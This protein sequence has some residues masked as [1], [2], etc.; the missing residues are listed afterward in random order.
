MSDIELLQ[1]RVE[2]ER[3]ARKAAE[4]LLEQKSLEVYQKN[5]EFKRLADHNHA[6]VETAAEGIISYGETGVIETFNR[7][8]Q[9]IFRVCKDQVSSI[10]ALFDLSGEERLILFPRRESFLEQDED[11]A[12]DV[13]AE[14]RDP[15][16]LWGRRPDGELFSVEVAVSKIRTDGN[17]LYTALVRDLTRRRILESRLGQAQK[18][19][20]VGQL[21]A[22]ISHEINTP[23]QFVGDNIQ[24]LEAAFQDVGLLLDLYQELQESIRAKQSTDPILKKIAKQEEIV[25]LSFLRDEFPEAIDQAIEGIDRVSRVVRAMKEFSQPNSESRS[26]FDV[27]R[28]IESTLA[29][30][31]NQ[32]RDIA[33]ITVDLD[34]HL[35]PLP[36][37]VSQ[38]NQTLLNMIS[39]AV[40]AIAEQQQATKGEIWISTHHDDEGVEILIRDNGPGIAPEIQGRIFDPFFTTK[41]V[42]KGMGQGL[43]FVYDVIVDKHEGT[44]QVKSNPSQGTSFLVRLPRTERGRDKSKREKDT[45]KGKHAN[46]I[47]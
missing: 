44:I 10:D 26:L 20:S 46:S 17:T 6:I 33:D 4:M 30:I 35:E 25:D 43:A 31:A 39:N 45:S 27:N 14:E 23:I 9:Q 28:A 1:R 34:P 18:M 21:A 3:A 32:A 15:I 36:C 11:K 41:E 7:S 22:G 47:D 40:E 5:Q 29:I 13:Q 19:E 24:F 38:M 37:L 8:A 2:R 12:F 16:E 42:G